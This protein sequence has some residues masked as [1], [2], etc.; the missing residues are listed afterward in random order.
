MS[1][2]SVVSAISTSAA[3]LSSVMVDTGNV[4]RSERGCDLY[5]DRRWRRMRVIGSVK[6]RGILP[7]RSRI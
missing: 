5:G 6:M 2:S 1:A 7:Q 4:Q 3:G